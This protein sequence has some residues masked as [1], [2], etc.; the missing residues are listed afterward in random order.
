MDAGRLFWGLLQHSRKEIL[1]TWFRV[2]AGRWRELGTFEK[3]FVG[4]I[5]KICQWILKM[6]MFLV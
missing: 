3:D 5:Y 1:V 2:V 6:S 4:L